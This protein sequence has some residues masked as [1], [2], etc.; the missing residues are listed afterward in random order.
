MNNWLAAGAAPGPFHYTPKRWSLLL[1]SLLL[2][3][4]THPT[5]SPRPCGRPFL[6]HARIA[7]CVI[8]QPA[9]LKA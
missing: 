8:G 7:L 4:D 6:H 2:L 9:P 3:Q 5:A 1:Q